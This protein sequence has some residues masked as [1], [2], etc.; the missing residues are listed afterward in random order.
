MTS[1]CSVCPQS[2]SNGVGWWTAHNYKTDPPTVSNLCPSCYRNK[3][4]IAYRETIIEALEAIKI[5][6]QEPALHVA[7]Q[8]MKQ[9]C[10]GKVRD[11][12][13]ND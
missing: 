12:K 7:M 6:D 11:L 10:I 9:H 1:K 3:S 4:L 13:F 8:V 2:S 5:T